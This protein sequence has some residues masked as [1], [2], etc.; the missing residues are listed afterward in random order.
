MRYLKSWLLIVGAFSAIG[1]GGSNDTTIVDPD[2]GGL[3]EP[4]AEQSNGLRCEYGVDTT[5]RSVHGYDCRCV[6][7]GYWECDLVKVVCDGDLG[8][9][10]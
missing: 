4:A 9:T 7:T 6:C 10:D 1:C 5:C 8:K 2:L 3:C